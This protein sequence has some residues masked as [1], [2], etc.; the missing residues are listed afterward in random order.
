MKNK[1]L[2]KLAK[3]GDDSF[4]QKRVTSAS[5]PTHVVDSQKP[6]QHNDIPHVGHGHQK[7]ENRTVEVIKADS[8][9]HQPSDEAACGTP[10]PASG[11]LTGPAVSSA[12]AMLDDGHSKPYWVEAS[13][14]KPRELAETNLEIG[15]RVEADEM[16]GTLIGF[17]DADFILIRFDAQIVGTM[18]IDEKL[19]WTEVR[20]VT[21]TAPPSGYR[22]GDKVRHIKCGIGT[23]VN[24]EEGRYEVDFAPPYGTRR[25]MRAFLDPANEL[26]GDIL[27]SAARAR[28]EQM[29]G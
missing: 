1:D 6:L 10:R 13:R 23:V 12:A 5:A 24:N 18:P 19:V 29:T 8:A 21:V 17:H 3:V 22:V 28:A 2:L 20:H 26:A 27:A 25:I 4:H 9:V 16:D 7:P 11:A 14:H 15:A